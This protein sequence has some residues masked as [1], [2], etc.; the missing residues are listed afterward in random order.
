MDDEDNDE[1]HPIF[2]RSIEDFDY[3]SDGEFATD[4][5]A[6]LACLEA[7]PELPRTISD[8]VLYGLGMYYNSKTTFVQQNFWV[9]MMLRCESEVYESFVKCHSEDIRDRVSPTC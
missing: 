6:Y 2:Q 8:K 7:F 3:G 1:V 9:Y 4:N 5:I